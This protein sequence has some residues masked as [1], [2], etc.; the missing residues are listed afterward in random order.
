MLRSRYVCALLLLA[1]VP[2]EAARLTFERTVAARHD[3]VGAQDLLITYAI[4]DTEKISAFLDVF[5]DQ[6]NRGDTLRVVDATRIEHSTERSHRWRKAPKYVEQRSPADAFIRVQ[7]FSCHT[8][9][10]SGERNGYDID[11][12]RIRITQRWVDAVCEAHIDAI[13]KR[14][15]KKVAEITVRGEG[16]SP[17]VDEVTDGERDT[18]LDQAARYAAVAAAEE[19]KPRRV[20]ETIPLID[21][22]PR[23]QEGMVMIDADRLDEARR[24]WERAIPGNL[25]SAALHFNLA[26]V[27]EALGDLKVA[28]QN[29]AAAEALAPKNATFRYEHQMFRKRYGLKR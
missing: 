18:A 15:G 10:R 26:A 24:I 17:R 3:L 2:A 5:I 8:M 25:K 16:T 28:D 23:F 7:A 21:D 11:G 29:Y 20:R 14:N 1:A 9:D 4:A 6:A 12:N 27:C 13:A 19:I 22:A